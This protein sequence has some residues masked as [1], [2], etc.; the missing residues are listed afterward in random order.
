MEENYV[1]KNNIF[2]FI[3]I[4]SFGF[5]LHITNLETSKSIVVVVTDG[6][7]KRFKGKR[8]DLSKRAFEILSN[9]QLNKGLL[10]VRIERSD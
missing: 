6:I 8:I 9:G 5:R 2:S 4:Y 1:Y 10:Q 7:G 3:Y